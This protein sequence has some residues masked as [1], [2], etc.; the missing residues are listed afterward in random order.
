MTGAPGAGKSTLVDRLI[1]RIRND[2]E[3][4][5][6]LAIDP[7][8]PFSGGAVLGDR[9]RM[10][11]HIT[12]P[13]V[14]IR[15]LDTRGHL[16]GLSRATPQAS[17][18]LEGVGFREIVIETVGVGQAE[19]AVAAQTDTTLVVVN[20]GWGDSVQA[21]KAGLLEVGDIFVVNKA[22]R[23]GVEQTVTDLKQML[24]LGSP[25]PWWP[26]IVTTIAT[27]GEGV[28]RLWDAIVEHRSHLGEGDRREVARRHR[29]AALLR[30]TVEEE[31]R[32]VIGANVAGE[33]WEAALDEVMSRTTDPWAV[34]RR[35]TADITQR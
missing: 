35:L 27:E 8:S 12:D 28:E 9:V 10:Q 26:P 7:S 32:A 22:D 30:A 2:G 33:A 17:V 11:D 31:V 5:A 18:V 3:Q 13:G 29:T 16:G 4:V 34:A 25:Q 23:D 20:P 1:R 14:Y 6:V 19:V 21:A 24:Q 15:S